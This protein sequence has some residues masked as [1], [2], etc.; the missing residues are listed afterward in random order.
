MNDDPMEKFRAWWSVAT[1][2]SPLNQKS[3]VCVSTVDQNGYPSGRFVDLKEATNKGFGFCT[4]YLSCK[5]KELDVNPKIALT[6][7]W[8]HVGY[9]VRVKGMANPM[10]TQEANTN[11]KSRNKAGQLTTS[12]AK[13]SELLESYEALSEKLSLEETEYAQKEIPRPEDWGGFWVD[14]SSIEFLTFKKNRLHLREL[15]EKS[16]T[17]TW[18]MSL[19]QP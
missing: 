4:S 12:I 17:G 8:D 18:K 15:Y 10:S 1:T 16:T 7:W 13:Q 3:A 6:I 5:G 2:E 19:L 14:P 11:W 9:Q